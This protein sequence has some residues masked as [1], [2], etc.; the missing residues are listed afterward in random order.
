[1]NK[2]TI[3]NILQNV[4]REKSEQNM[5]Y[6]FIHDK[7]ITYGEFQNLTNKVSKGLISKGIKK[8][9][10]V[11]ILV[12]NSINWVTAFYAICNIGAVAVLLNI[13]LSS[14]EF[15][16]AINFAEVKYLFIT[17]M[18]Y[19]RISKAGQKT[20]P[21]ICLLN[22]DV[23]EQKY[24]QQLI[25]EGTM[26]SDKLLEERMKN[27]EENDVAALQFTSGTTGLPK[28]VEITHRNICFNAQ[29]IKSDLNY[30]EKDII[31]LG[32]P[33]Y[34]I[35]GYI[36][37]MMTAVMAG[38][39]ICLIKKFRTIIALQAIQELKCTSFHGVPI[40]YQYM[41]N[42]YKQFDISSLKKGFVAGAICSDS[43]INRIF[44]EFKLQQLLDTYGQTE[45]I[46]IASKNLHLEDYQKQTGFCVKPWVT[47][48]LVDS[49]GN[50]IEIA[51]QE[52]YLMI[53]TISLMEGYYKNEQATQN[54]MS[55]DW[56]L[57][58]DI[59]Q[60]NE[61]GTLQI[62]G[63]NSD[64]INRGGENISA[65][66]I[67]RKILEYPN[68]KD[69]VAIGVPDELYG[70]EVAVFVQYAKD[71]VY[72]EEELYQYMQERF[73]KIEIPK[74]LKK[75]DEIPYNAGGKVQKYKLLESLK[76]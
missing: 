13:E 30:T 3:G 43:L 57:T 73:A 68:V 56:F 61:D 33:L 35:L 70:Q 67:E 76:K 66:E 15:L 48:R 9:E 29:S 28:A 41:V 62:C 51:N 20:L 64:Y 60:I 4:S 22:S 37:T 52:G 47:Y 6:D 5:I 46:I 21:Q 55:D 25:E 34:H 49:E 26:T 44:K 32:A 40:M 2:Q 63:R 8:G 71:A 27:L 10:H 59:V 36:A 31:L 65:Y 38:A 16:Y 11:G 54:S 75:V 72:K 58:G 23:R 74:Y 53:K 1:M 24:L 19:E 17:E 45:S 18:L 14:E 69:A 50:E 39:S 7:A 42:K 12:D